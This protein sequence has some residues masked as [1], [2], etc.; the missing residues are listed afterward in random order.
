V[1][2]KAFSTNFPSVIYEL[3]EIWRKVGGSWISGGKLV[4]KC[5]GKLVGKALK[6]TCIPPVFIREFF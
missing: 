4:G 5:C 6:S 2:S 3:V 1:D